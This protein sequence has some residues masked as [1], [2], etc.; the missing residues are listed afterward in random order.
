V[1]V[2]R[3]RCSVCRDYFP[4]DEVYY[5]NSVSRICSESCLTDLYERKKVKA[6][7]D[8]P[9]KKA[10]SGGRRL[11]VELRRKIRER[12][13]NVCR[14]CGKPGE[15][16]HHVRYRSQGGPDHPGNLV[17]LC[18]HHHRVVHGNKRHWQPTLLALLWIGY[19]EG[20]WL[21]VPE[22]ERRLLRSGLIQNLPRA[23]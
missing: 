1:P 10:A 18:G 4:R 19:V 17:L 6:R 20:K 13:G 12:D 9:K 23:A 15:E 7:N 3:V 14:W 8:R 21:T 2:A 22:V 11:D 5:A 16:V